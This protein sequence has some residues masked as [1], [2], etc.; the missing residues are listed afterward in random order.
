RHPEKDVLAYIMTLFE[1]T[2]CTGTDLPLPPLASAW[3]QA[4]AAAGILP[5]RMAQIIRERR[6]RKLRL[7]L[8]E[9]KL[10]ADPKVDTALKALGHKVLA[11][12][13]SSVPKTATPA[14]PDAAAGPEAAE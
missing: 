10:T 7:Y 1:H 11:E 6:P 9:P 2:W 14:D 8:A 13:Q 3:A 5:P 12:W 4:L